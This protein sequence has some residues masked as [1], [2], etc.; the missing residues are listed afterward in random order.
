[1]V[2]DWPL[3]VPVGPDY[4]LTHSLMGVLVACLPLG[5]ALTLLFIKILS[6]PLFELA[7]TGLQQR[8]V[9]F[10]QAPCKISVRGVMQL[11]A[12]VCV[13][14]TTH[15][16]WDAFTHGATWGVAMFPSL[17]RVWVSVMGVKI[18]GY[19]VLQHGSSLIG[20]PFLLLIFAH[21]YRCSEP[22]DIPDLVISRLARRVW[23]TLMIGL[24]LGVIVRHIA[25]VQH[26]ALLPVLLALTYGVTESGFLLMLL[27]ACYGL[28][29]YPALRFKQKQKS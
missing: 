26:D 3:Y 17:T 29:F 24:P 9:Q 2:P 22:Q 25:D 1:M 27:V 5:L 16:V 21:W 23:L 18:L 28:L 13:G 12:A 8:L 7:P 19:Q 6:R 10:L 14:A 11:A 4:Q 15:I 20:L